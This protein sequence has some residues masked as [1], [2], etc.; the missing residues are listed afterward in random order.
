VDVKGV[1]RLNQPVET[2][3]DLHAL[4]AA[5]KIQGQVDAKSLRLVEIS[6]DG[7]VLDTAVP[8]QFDSSSNAP[9]QGTFTFMLTGNT[10]ADAL[11][12]YLLY[13]DLQGH[14]A[15]T[16]TMMPLVSVADVPYQGQDTLRITT[17]A[18]ASRATKVTILDIDQYTK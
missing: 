13:F 1:A 17:V 6:P 4:L 5:Q 7:L 16:L 14:D 8:C 2:P 3:I 9:Q 12:H 10:A 11:R 18:S 15:P